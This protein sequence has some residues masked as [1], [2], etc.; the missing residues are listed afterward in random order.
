MDQILQDPR[1][2]TISVLFRDEYEIRVVQGQGE[3]LVEDGYGLVALH[4]ENGA[5]AD[6]IARL[7]GFAPLNVSPLFSAGKSE[8]EL[9]QEQAKAQAALG[10]GYP[11]QGSWA[12]IS[13][14]FVKHPDQVKALA[15]TL[16]AAPAV[17]LASVVGYPSY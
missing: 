13:G 4:D 1:P 9:D 17:R 3:F 11:N 6:V 14:D 8:Q 12:I 5:F 15:L 16:Q 10:T 2:H 7:K